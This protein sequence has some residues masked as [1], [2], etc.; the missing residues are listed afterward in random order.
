MIKTS[1]IQAAVLATCLCAAPWAN[2]ATTM[3]KAEYRAAKDRITETYK[4]DKAA[5]DK[6][7]N[8]PKDVCVEEAKAKEKVAKAELE[9]SYTGKM[10]DRNHLAVV[11]AET[12]YEVAKEK[13]DD[14]SGN[15]KDVCVKEAKAAETKAKAEAKMNKE[16]GESA[17]ETV[18]DKNDADYKVAKEKCDALSGDAKSSCMDKVKAHYNK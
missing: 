8:N 17:K 5:C 11:K 4:A 6:L 13:C 14:K 10:S 12:A 16:V 2:A 1:T 15:D 7:T 9:Y 18:D 3:S